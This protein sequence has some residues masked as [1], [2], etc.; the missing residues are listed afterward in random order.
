MRS[1]TRS[2][3]PP[4]VPLR[5]RR[6]C[7]PNAVRERHHHAM[8]GLTGHF[9][10]QAVLDQVLDGSTRP[11]LV[12][13]NTPAEFCQRNRPTAPEFG[14]HVHCVTVVPA[15]QATFAR[16]TWICKRATSRRSAPVDASCSISCSSPIRCYYRLSGEWIHA[17]I[18]FSIA[19]E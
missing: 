18:S 1:I 6:R 5:S 17:T 15:Q 16:C 19:T 10:D 12:E 14:E 9:F 13:A 2:D 4:S 8:V 7:S 3:R 11:A